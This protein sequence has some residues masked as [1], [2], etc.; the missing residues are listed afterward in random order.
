MDRCL[1]FDG[2]G[3]FFMDENGLLSLRGAMPQA[4]WAY[5][6]VQI[7]DPCIVDCEP[8]DPFSFMRIWRRL[9]SEGALFGAPLGGFW[10]HV[11]D[12]QARAEAEARMAAASSR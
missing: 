10:M 12:P 11:G 5:T 8:L 6:G 2:A 1:G 3:D 9:Q 4:P 7:I